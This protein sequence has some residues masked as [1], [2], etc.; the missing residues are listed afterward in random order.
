MP[1]A[2]TKTTRQKLSA[3]RHPHKADPLD[4][5][6]PMSPQEAWDWLRA[7]RAKAAAAGCSIDATPDLSPILAAV[8][9]DDDRDTPPPTASPTIE[10]A[11]ATVASFDGGDCYA[12]MTQTWRALIALW[13]GRDQGPA[14]TA[15]LLGFVA[16]FAFIGTY[17]GATSRIRLE[18]L[19]PNPY[20]HKALVQITGTHSGIEAPFW[21]ALRAWLFASPPAT[22]AQAVAAFTPRRHHLAQVNTQDT[23]NT[24]ERG[25]LNFAFSRDPVWATED[26]LAITRGDTLRFHNNAML[27]AS[28]TD[29]ALARALIGRAFMFPHELIGLGYDLLESLGDD[30]LSVLEAFD[31]CN[32]VR[33]DSRTR[34][35]FDS[36]LKLARSGQPST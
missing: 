33:M 28:L 32:T 25:Y 19:E 7:R 22:Y 23:D 11:R 21:C 29:P 14:F 1:I 3:V 16:P 5:K 2:W 35:P 6:A 12:M 30:A 34:R 9:S 36:L 15:S 27:V 4:L 13:M 24:R 10:L 26:A 8:L 31:A 18:P 20:G 17:S